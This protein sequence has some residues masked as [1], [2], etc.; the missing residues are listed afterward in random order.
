MLRTLRLSECDAVTNFSG[1]ASATQLRHVS[2]DAVHLKSIHALRNA[3]SSLR[4][5]DVSGN[6]ELVDISPLGVATAL[7]EVYLARTDIR[8]LLPLIACS[9]TLETLDVSNCARLA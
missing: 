1:L 7:A 6:E 5:V 4:V 3:G 8:N 9:A 2:L